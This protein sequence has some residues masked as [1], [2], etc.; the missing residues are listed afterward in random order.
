[1]KKNQSKLGALNAEVCNA[2]IEVLS[3]ILKTVF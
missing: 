1:M 2:Y 3:S